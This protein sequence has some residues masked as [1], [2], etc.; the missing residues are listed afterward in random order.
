LWYVSPTMVHMTTRDLR[1]SARNASDFYAPLGLSLDTST[2]RVAWQS[3]YF[4]G[5]PG[6][7][8]ENYT[9]TTFALQSSAR[10]QAASAGG[11]LYI[12]GA[13]LQLYDGHSCTE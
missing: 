12:A 6:S 2:G 3:L 13:P 10:R 4:A 7:D 8:V 9:V 5:S 11:L 1:N